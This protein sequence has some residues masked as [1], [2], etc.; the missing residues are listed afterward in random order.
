MEHKTHQE[1]TVTIHWHD[2]LLEIPKW[3]IEGYAEENISLDDKYLDELY[4]YRRPPIFSFQ[5]EPE[6]NHVF[7][8]LMIAKLNGIRA[9]KSLG[10]FV[11][12]GSDG[13]KI[14][15]FDDLYE[16]ILNE[17]YRSNFLGYESSDKA[18]VYHAKVA[19]QR[20][21]RGLIVVEPTEG[22]AMMLQELNDYKRNMFAWFYGVRAQK[23][24]N[25]GH[26]N[27]LLSNYTFE[28]FR[29]QQCK[30]V[31]MEFYWAL[32]SSIRY[33]DDKTNR[34]KLPLGFPPLLYIL[35]LRIA[36]TNSISK[37]GRKSS[38]VCPFT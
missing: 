2:E 18:N 6:Y 8:S 17:N 21:L 9:K 34:K 22:A 35:N 13:N 25:D 24:F 26:G 4:S 30:A 23:C 32:A 10:K 15:T 5:T 27:P 20:H 12:Y 14:A 11:M 16:I 31:S 19:K 7:T 29:K 38:S 33:N 1:D 28:E 36:C 3:I 37:I